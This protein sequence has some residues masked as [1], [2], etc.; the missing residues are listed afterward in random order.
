MLKSENYGIHQIKTMIQGYEQW[1]KDS[2]LC[3]NTTS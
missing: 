3:R 1:L 2:G